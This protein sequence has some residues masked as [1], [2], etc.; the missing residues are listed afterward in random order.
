M[1]DAIRDSMAKPK[2]KSNDT[3]ANRDFEAKYVKLEAQKKQ[4]ADPEGRDEYH[5]SSIFWD[6]TE[7]RW[8]HLKASASQPT[9]GTLVD[10]EMVEIEP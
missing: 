10:D 4:D 8:Q 3:G 9:I 5:V 1:H 7:A 2:A 6:P